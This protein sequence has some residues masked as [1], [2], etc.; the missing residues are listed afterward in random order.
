MK[1][2]RTNLDRAFSGLNRSINIQLLLGFGFFFLPRENPRVAE[3]VDEPE[4]MAI[5]LL[6][7]G[8]NSGLYFKRLKQVYNDNRV[9]GS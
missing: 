4:F 6:L 5:M 8:L 1:K 3:L 9:A 7:F 2:K